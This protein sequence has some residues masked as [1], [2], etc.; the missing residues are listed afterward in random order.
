MFRKNWPNLIVGTVVLVA[1]VLSA[2]APAATP[3]PTTKPAAPTKAA[4]APTKAAEP[5]KPAAP[6]AATPKP[7]EAKPTPAAVKPLDPP[8][9][10][11][12]GVAPQLSNS[13]LYIAMEKGYFKQEGLNVELINFASDTEKMPPLLNGDI[14]AGVTLFQAAMFNAMARS[15]GVKIVSGAQ[16][17]TPGHG[18]V[19]FTIRKDLVDQIKDFKDLK[20][21][22]IARA[23]Q[24]NAADILVQKALAKGGLTDKDADIIILSA[25]DQNVALANK[26]IDVSLQT[27]PQATLGARQGLS[28]KWKTADEIYPNLEISA[29]AF[30]ERFQKEKPEVAKRFMVAIMRGARDFLD[31][32][33]KNKGDRQEMLAILMKYTGIKD[34]TLFDEVVLPDFEPNGVIN[35]KLVGDDL[36]YYKDKNLIQGNVNLDDLFDTQ[37][38]DYA[39][40]RLG[41]AQ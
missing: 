33:Q 4:P 31:V 18:G 21:R 39:I 25:A 38:L 5:T 13:A 22:K 35:T 8:V 20:G 36:Q 29:W 16:R 3:T 10:V 40:S 11:K 12:A 19:I 6:Q 37:Y 9:A 34:A 24:G 23:G 2:C 7:A 26:S 41:K 17:Y 28:V 15:V 32:F 27:E 1:L 14:E 30:S